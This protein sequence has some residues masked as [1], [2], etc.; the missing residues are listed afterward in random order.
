MSLNSVTLTVQSKPSI[1]LAE[2]DVLIKLT[3][4]YLPSLLDPTIVGSEPMRYLTVTSSLVSVSRLP[5][6]IRSHAPGLL[7]KSS[8]LNVK[9]TAWVTL[10]PEVAAA[11]LLP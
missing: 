9:L 2:P 8:S 1:K 4:K 3:S 11:T 7:K 5:V 6:L 10:K